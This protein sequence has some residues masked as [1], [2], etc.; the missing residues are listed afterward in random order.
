MDWH[1]YRHDLPA[2]SPLRQVLGPA[3]L[4]VNDADFTDADFDGIRQIGASGKRIA[5][6]KTG[7]YGVGFNTAYNVTDYPSF[8]SRAWMICFDPHEN[9]VAEHHG[10]HGRGFALSELRSIHPLW[11]KCFEVAGLDLAQDNC[12]GTI[13]RLPLRT[14]AQAKISEI[15]KEPFDEQ[16][17]RE[18]V[19]SLV[20]EGPEM[21]LFTRNI[22]D[23]SVE[24]IPADGSSRKELLSVSTENADAVE[25]SRRSVYSSA[26]KSMECAIYYH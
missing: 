8:L 4:L 9:A 3:L 12:S 23:F 13:F 5:V 25:E 15:S 19:A 7:R 22:L 20:E 11:L 6:S 17:F 24:E 1:D 18:V 16:T 26:D 21:L 10:D 2:D 14:P